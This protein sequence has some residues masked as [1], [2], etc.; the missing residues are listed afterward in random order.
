MKQWMEDLKAQGPKDLLL[1]VV[2][3]KTDLIDN[4]KVSYE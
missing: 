4:E 3:N 1:A 2:G